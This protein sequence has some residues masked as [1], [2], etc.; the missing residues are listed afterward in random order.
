MKSSLAAFSSCS[1]IR[2][3]LIHGGTLCLYLAKIVGGKPSIGIKQI[4][5]LLSWFSII[6]NK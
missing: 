1:D 4:L 2:R 6:H 5:R 3:K